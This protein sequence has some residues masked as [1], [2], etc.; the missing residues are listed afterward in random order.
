MLAYTAARP[1]DLKPS[2]TEE[3]E[4][5]LMAVRVHRKRQAPAAVVAGTAVVA[6]ARVVTGVAAHSSKG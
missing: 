5:T 3:A 2:M 4:H 1:A 6:G